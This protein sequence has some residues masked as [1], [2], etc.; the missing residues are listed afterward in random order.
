MKPFSS[1]SMTRGS[2]PGRRPR[3]YISALGLLAVLGLV[4]PWQH[5]LAYFA[6]GGSVLPSVFFRDATAN[7]L[8]TAITI[9]VYLAALAFSLGVA[10]DRRIGARRWAYLPLCFFVGLAFALPLYLA[11]RAWHRG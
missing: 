5:H 7:A 10:A 9:D 6:S 8:T 11:D 2:T 1:H 4:L 3:F